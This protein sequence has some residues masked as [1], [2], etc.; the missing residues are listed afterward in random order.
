MKRKSRK[1]KRTKH[2]KSRKTR[3]T[4][5]ARA[6][7]K[8]ATKKR[9]ARETLQRRSTVV[10]PVRRA[11]IDPRALAV[12]SDMRRGVSL[13][14]AARQQ[15]IKQSTV[16][17]L[18]GHTLYRS[19]HGKPWRARKSDRL[20]AL[21]TILTP[22]GTTFAEVRNSVERTRLA[23]YDNALRNFR[24]GADRA[25][26]ELQAFKGQTVGGHPL[27]TDPDLLIQ[28]EEAGSLDFDALYYSVGERK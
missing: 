22:H 17:R 27:I 23:R 3:R 5:R 25:V 12:V 13:A 26:V 28:L 14:K 24:A 6:S 7:R 16:L 21:M 11:V 10:S 4:A 8:R 20:S 1:S 18:V 9:F 15:H 2:V 19:G